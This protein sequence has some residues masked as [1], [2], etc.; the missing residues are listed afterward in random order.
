MKAAQLLGLRGPWQ[1]Q[2][3]R[4]T[5]CVRLRSYGPIRVFSRA[6]CSWRSEG[7]LG[8]SFSVA[9]PLQA[10]RGLPCLGS[11]SGSARQAHRGAPWLGSCSGVQRVRHGKGRLG[12][13]PGLEFIA[14]GWASLSVVQLP[15]LPSEGREAVVMAPPTTQDSAV[16]P[17]FHGCLAFLHRHFPPQSHLPSIRLSTVNISP[18]PGITPQSLN[19]SSQLL[20][21]PGNPRPCPGDAWLPQGLSDSH[22]I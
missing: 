1:R 13:G 20:R 18:H 21:L 9:P 5:D 11:F 16:W 10:F 8:W 14:S 2:A 12:W 15:M 17:G 6:S 4:D 3:C 22:S 7:L 19:S